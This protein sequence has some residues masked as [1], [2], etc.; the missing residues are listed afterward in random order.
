MTC[1]IC[2]WSPDNPDY[3][4]VYEDPTW[5]VVL[6]PNQCLLG[7]C[8][9]HLKRHCG[10]LA[11]ITSDEVLD[12]LNVVKIM[13]TALRKAFDTTMFNWSCYMNLSY[14]ESLPDPHIHWWIVPRY[15]HTVQIG[16]LVFEDP[17]FGNP[18]DHEMWRDIPK[19]IRHQ[20]VERVQKAIKD[21]LSTDLST[22]TAS[23]PKT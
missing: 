19:E 21:K 17:L 6:A 10:D 15:N 22:K 14:R 8:V 13:E 20:I 1:H 18:Y 3:L 5:R 7:R 11:E 2:A 4:L 16:S 9:I 23:Q 12:W